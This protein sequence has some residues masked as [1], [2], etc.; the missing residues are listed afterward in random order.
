MRRPSPPDEP[1]FV[2]AARTM[3]ESGEWLLPMRGS[4]LYAEKP[5]PFMWLQAAA[6][7]VVGS[8]DVAFLLPSLIAAL[9]T[10]W[11][12]YDIARRSWGREVGGYAA[13]ALFATVQFGL[14]AKRAQID[15]VLVAMTT[16]AL[17]GLLRHLLKGPDWTGLAIAGFL[18]GL[19]TVTK[20]VGFLPLALLVPFAFIRHRR[21]PG[22]H[23]APGRTALVLMLAFVAGTL[24]WLGPLG[25]ALLGDNDPVLKSYA[26]ELLFKQTG[27]RYVAAWHHVQPAWY[28]LKVIATVW[29]PGCLLLPW[30]IAPWWRRCRRGDARYI[31]LLGWAVLVFIFFTVSP[32]KREVYIF[33]AL[34]AVCIAAAPL[35]RSVLLLRVPAIVLRTYLAVVTVISMAIGYGLLS[36]LPA[37]QKALAGRDVAVL[38]QH[39]LGIWMIVISGALFVI[40]LL[41]RRT[42]LGVALVSASAVLWL[43][44]GIG[45]MPT[46]DPYASSAQLMQ[47]VASRMSATDELGMIDWREQ[48]YLQSDRAVRDFGFK[49][50]IA[51]QWTGAMRWVAE[52]PNTRYLM[53]SQQAASRCTADMSR[54]LVGMANR[55]VWL[56][57]RGDR[58]LAVCAA[59]RGPVE[60]GRGQSGVEE[61]VE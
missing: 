39:R 23:A 26:R 41:A 40:T 43:V 17:W 51:A 10:L 38:A 1:R 54:D 24:V 47:Q 25:I 56:L 37:V 5:P 15:M 59:A 6:Y 2:L 18:S 60:S 14:M 27:T 7:K 45:L 13:L 35:L 30:L 31:L 16:G 11:F 46:L 52:S 36:H 42:R 29:L 21:V 8:W 9:L 32:G 44:Y 55:N 58:A 3:V 33:P 28:Y 53:L 19:G 57:L 48:N 49:T 22:S 12:T 20:G 50:S 4:Q 61:Q 34:P